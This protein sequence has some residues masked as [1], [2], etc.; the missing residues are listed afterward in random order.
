[1]LNNNFWRGFEKESSM[2]KGQRSDESVGAK[3]ATMI[4]SKGRV[5]PTALP[6]S[7]PGSVPGQHLNP[8]VKLVSI[9]HVRGQSSNVQI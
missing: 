8:K 7:D 5:S 6:S 4:A 3:P 2:M 1:M 9:P